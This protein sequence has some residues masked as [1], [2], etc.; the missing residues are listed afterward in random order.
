MNI[1]KFSEKLQFTQNSLFAIISPAR[2]TVKTNQKFKLFTAPD[3]AILEN[4]VP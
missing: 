3:N 2:A 4:D 1:A